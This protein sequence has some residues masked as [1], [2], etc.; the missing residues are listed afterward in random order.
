LMSS[1]RIVA[2]GQLLPIVDADRCSAERQKTTAP[3]TINVPV[4]T[5][6]KQ[7]SAAKDRQHH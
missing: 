2:N 1:N 3:G 4:V 6:A 5:A 7:P